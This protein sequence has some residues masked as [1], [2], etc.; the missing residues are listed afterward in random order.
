ML[1]KLAKK[2]L[3]NCSINMIVGLSGPA[4][5]SISGQVTLQNLHAF[6]LSS[7][8]EQHQPQVFGQE[9]RP[10]VLVG[11][12]PAFGYRQESISASAF[13]FTSTIF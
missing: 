9:H 2:T 4:I 6:L 8:N 3:G 7:L 12:M 1:P 5:D 11:E 13:C 10:I